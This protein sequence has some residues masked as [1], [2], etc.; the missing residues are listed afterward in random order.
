[1]EG[2]A[3]HFR[4]SHILVGLTILAIGTSLPEIAVSIMGGL[5]KLT[6]ISP[7][8]D[9]IIIGNKVGSF[10]VQI[11][12][13]IG[14]LALSK[15]LIISKW[16]LKREGL[17][18]IISITIFFLLALDGVVSQIDAVIMIIIYLSYLIFIIW[19]EKKI[20]H[21][22][23]EIINSE[24]SRLEAKDFEPIESPFKKPTIRKDILFF[25]IGLSLL[26]ISAEITILVAHDLAKEL[27]IPGNVIGILI[28]GFGTSIPELV[29]DLTAIRRRSYGIAIGDILGSNICDILLATGSG[30]IFINF[31]VAPI[32]LIFDVPMLFIAIFLACYLLWT[33]KTL[34]RWEGALLI[35]FYMNYVILKL[36]FFQSIVI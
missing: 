26:L 14:L 12:L 28:V 2:I 19:S 36:C 23:Q 9:G 16:E 21:H 17:M 5:D 27:N 11:T 1:M 34:K 6:G 30:A 3:S 20:A 24:K 4:I 33:Q 8:I 10:L 25:L 7:N 31:N 22:R 18:M 32:I 29:A 13:I 35:G 15:P